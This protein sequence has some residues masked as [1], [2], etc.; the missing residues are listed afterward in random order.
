MTG[1]VVSGFLV[2]AY[3]GPVFAMGVSVVRLPMR[4]LATAVM[5]IVST[6]VG[7]IIGPFLVGALNDSLAAEYGELAVRY[8]MLPGAVSAVIAGL[9]FW[10]AGNSLEADT[11][12]ALA[13]E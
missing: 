7:Q 1:F 12:R 9:C 10:L 3:W 4:A 11:A 8:S 2:L 6:L 5:L 13:A